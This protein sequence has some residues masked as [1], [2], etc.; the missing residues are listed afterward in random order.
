MRPSLRLLDDGLIQR[1]VGEARDIL[2][3]LGVEI[4]NAPILEMLADHGAAVDRS[5]WRARLTPGII[6]RALAYR[7]A[8]VQAV[9]RARQRDARL[10]RPQRVLHPGVGGHQRP[11]RR[12]AGTGSRPPPTT[13]KY[14]KV[15]SG[16]PHIASQSTALHPGRRARAAISDSYRLYLS[17]LYGEKPVVTGAFTIE[18]FEVMKDLQLA[19]R[20]SAQALAA[21]PLAIFSCCPTAP[22][23]WSDVTSQNLVDCA[24]SVDPGRVHLDAA[25]GLHGARDAGRQPRPADRRDAERHRDQPARRDRARRSSTA[26]LRRSS[27]CATRPRRWARS[28]R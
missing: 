10:R 28:R 1:I 19:V 6:D 3:R 20:G 27:T 12:T 24:R 17:L 4:H 11:R 18:A 21:K 26:A 8:L 2:C 16:L 14:V 15:V 13:C 22:I 7:R 23:K 5:T 25:L 9:R